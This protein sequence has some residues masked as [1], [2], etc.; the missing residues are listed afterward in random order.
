MNCYGFFVYFK[1]ICLIV[2]TLKGRI[3]FPKRTGRRSCSDSGR[4]ESQKLF[5]KNWGG[6]VFPCNE[7]PRSRVFGVFFVFS[8]V[9][10]GRWFRVGEC[11]FTYPYR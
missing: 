10:H 2:T 6:K 7:T 5:K 3:R 11:S 4:P 8:C 1:L 9:F